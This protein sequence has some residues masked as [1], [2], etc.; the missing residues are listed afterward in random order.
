MQHKMDSNSPKVMESIKHLSPIKQFNFE[1][2]QIDDLKI[3]TGSN[4][5]Q[6]RSFEISNLS[7]PKRLTGQFINKNEL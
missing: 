4:S 2:E 5:P 1:D 3:Y 7:I 6:D